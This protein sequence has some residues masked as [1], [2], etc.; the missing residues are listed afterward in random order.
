MTNRRRSDAGSDAGT[1]LALAAL[2]VAAVGLLLLTALVMPSVVGIVGVVV[3]F[4][5][6]AAFHY[7]VWGWWLSRRLPPDESIEKSRPRWPPPVE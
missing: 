5:L 7:L 1:F 3:A 4:V 2:I 6:F